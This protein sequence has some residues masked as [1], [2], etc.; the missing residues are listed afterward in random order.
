[1][2]RVDDHLVEPEVTRDEIVRGQRVYA[3]PAKEPHAERHF[4]LIQVIG[5]LLAPGY[6]GAADLLTRFGP[7][8]DFA[9]DTSVRR[10]GID[11]ETGSRYLEELAFE[12]VSAQ[13]LRD[14][15]I[16]AEDVTQR[17]VRRLIAIFVKQ[18]TVREWSRERND[19]VTLPLDSMLEDP[20]LVRPVPVRALLDAAAA[21]E[22]IVDA[23]DSK[24]SPKLK[25]I[26]ATE[27]A[28]GRKEGHEEGRK[29]GLDEGLE[30]G[31]KEGLE[32]AV[33]SVC[34]AFGLPFG[35]A[36]RARL[37]PLDSTDL[38]ALLERLQTERRWPL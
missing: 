6:I 7:R 21:D 29:E 31:R 32:T 18:G 19:W 28:E 16:R 38:E 13:S 15:T 14:I 3:A 17:G 4:E 23:L 20:V 1:M 22:A 2:P 37:E 12:V 30:Q 9:T 8:S 36:E 5:P 10:V 25:E 33:A 27:R 26:R 34:Q 24:G 11:P 35:A